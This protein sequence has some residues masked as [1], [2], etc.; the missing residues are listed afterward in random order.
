[1][2]HFPFPTI[3]RI[4]VQVAQIQA[5][6]NAKQ[7]ALNAQIASLRIVARVVCIPCLPKRWRHRCHK[8]GKRHT[9]KFLLILVDYCNYHDLDV[10]YV[11]NEAPLF[12]GILVIEASLRFPT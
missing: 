10:L 7:F 4:F 12:N 1:M 2:I 5:Q 11:L 8:A 6:K 9:T 3:K